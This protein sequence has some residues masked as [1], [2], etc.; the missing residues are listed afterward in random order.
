MS[1]HAQLQDAVITRYGERLVGAPQRTFDAL[2]LAFDN[3]LNVELR[4]ASADEY[5]IYWRWRDHAFRIDTAPLHPQLP[6]FPQHLHVDDAAPRADPWTVPG[7]DPWVNL[8]AVL[9]AILED[10]GLQRLTG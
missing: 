7:R 8:Q 2:A 5:S 4:Y 6:T 10:P 1:L 9:D 3:G